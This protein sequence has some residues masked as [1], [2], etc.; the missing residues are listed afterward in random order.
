MS[1][2]LAGTTALRCRQTAAIIN[3]APA[4]GR[5]KGEGK[6]LLR[7]LSSLWT[8]F[9]RH[10][11]RTSTT[12]C[13][14]SSTRALAHC[15]KYNTAQPEARLCHADR[16]AASLSASLATAASLSAFLA[17]CPRDL[18]ERPFEES[19][20]CFGI[21]GLSCNALSGDDSSSTLGPAVVEFLS[22]CNSYDLFATGCHNAP[23]LSAEE[24]KN[25]VTCQDS[26]HAVALEE[27]GTER[28]PGEKLSRMSK[29]DLLFQSEL[30]SWKTSLGQ[31][32]EKVIPPSQANN[33]R[34]RPV[35]TCLGVISLRL[36]PCSYH[37]HHRPMIIGLCVSSLRPCLYLGY[38]HLR[39]IITGL[40]LKSLDR[41]RLPRSRAR[42]RKNV[43][44]ISSIQPGLLDFA[45]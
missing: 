25:P 1:Q 38:R 35:I 15:S 24:K 26:S 29:T 9:S 27:K 44:V 32:Q 45:M 17:S 10:T 19:S 14:G 3:L 20:G 40:G 7:A 16:T 18:P 2:L 41:A 39:P 36:C 21:P 42:A 12:V 23:G 13:K 11:T 4:N 31:D 33:Y 37:R 43:S 6:R 5:A 22:T 30:E 8:N 28:L 34:L